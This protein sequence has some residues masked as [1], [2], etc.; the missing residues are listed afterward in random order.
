MCGQF[1]R[2]VRTPI[3]SVKSNAKFVLGVRVKTNPEL[4]F[5]QG[6]SFKNSTNKQNIP[7]P[8]RWVCMII[9]KEEEGSGTIGQ[10]SQNSLNLFANTSKFLS[11]SPKKFSCKFLKHSRNLTLTK[12]IFRISF[13]YL[14]NFQ[15]KHLFSETFHMPSF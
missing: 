9:S 7:Q 15:K 3:D 6:E 5:G 12:K 11:T 14:Q 4:H 1:L 8:H 10:F 13:R 2:P